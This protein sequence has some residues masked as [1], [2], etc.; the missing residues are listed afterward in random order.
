VAHDATLFFWSD[1]R[2]HSLDQ[3]GMGDENLHTFFDRRSYHASRFEVSMVE[4]MIVQ[5]IPSAQRM[6]SHIFS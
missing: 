2:A 4:R 6:G 5:E 3:L 1:G